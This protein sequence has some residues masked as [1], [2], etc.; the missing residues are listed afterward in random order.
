[1]QR[2]WRMDPQVFGIAIGDLLDE[3][4]L[5]QVLE[6]RAQIRRHLE[7]PCHDEL[8][9]LL[10]DHRINIKLQSAFKHP[11]ERFQNPALEVEI[12]FFVEDF[13]EAGN[14]HDEADLAV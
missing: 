3:F 7:F 12:I 1:R 11:A 6:K 13:Q 4:I 2:F 14:A 5:D 10:V 8:A 9:S